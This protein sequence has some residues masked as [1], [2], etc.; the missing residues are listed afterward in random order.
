MT[1]QDALAILKSGVNV[2]LTGEPGAGKSHT[3]REFV[4]YLRSCGIEPAITASTGIAATHIGGMTIHSWSGIGIAKSL[5]KNEL[6][7]IAGKSNV[8]KRVKNT[9]TLIIDEI[10]MLNG[11]TLGLVDAVCKR[12]RENMQPFGGMQVVFV[13]DFFQLPPI[14]RYDEPP[15][16]FAFLSDAWRAANPTVCYLS[17]QHRQE[18]AAFLGVLSALR[19][20]VLDEDHVALLKERQ[21]IA[22]P[23][24]EITTLF[25][26]NA[27]V[28]KINNAHLAK[29]PNE[30]HTFTMTHHGSASLI[31]Q[32]Q[33][34]CLS[35]EKLTL[36]VGARVMFTKNHF[37]EGFVNGTTGEVVGF[38]R[39]TKMP[40]IQIR[41]GRKIE[42]TT[43]TW[44]IDVDGH[45]LA[46]IHQLP[47]RLAWAMTVHKSQGM[48]LDAA[49]IDLAQAFAF[50]QGYVAL[51]RVRTLSG[52]YLGGL[53]ARALD[54]DPN[55][56]S[57]DITFRAASDA[58]QTSLS[59]LETGDV[60]K[61]H[62]QF[63]FQCGGKIGT[64]IVK[65]SAQQKKDA[66]YDETLAL[67]KAGKNLVDIAAARK[68]TVGTIITHCEKLHTMKKLLHADILH[69]TPKSMS[70]ISAAIEKHGTEALNPLYDALEG[71]V[72]YDGIR[73]GLLIV[74]V[75]TAS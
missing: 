22:V 31:E 68:L 46:S 20:N 7:N 57:H 40:I 52:L 10:S 63:L 54:V 44:A 65:K 75:Q 35:P 37:E 51:S 28:D 62:A 61:R 6:N 49:Y 24:E 53:N 58:A 55:V 14:A 11:A 13:G 34:G 29:L 66:R 19:Q 72:S 25:P 50:G 23:R 2:F 21:G 15:A 32:L 60:E 42:A 12:I 3:I 1:Q 67:L 45:A 41:S 43:D 64:P 18:D 5:N 8:A 59:S 70:E 73:L 27:D 30:T 9:H 26:H 16:Q 17:E 33:R 38:S 74:A 71:K 47:L 36:K 4:M 48:S 56:L 69:I 39:E